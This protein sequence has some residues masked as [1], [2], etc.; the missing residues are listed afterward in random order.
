MVTVGVATGFGHVVQLNPVAG[1][2]TKLLPPFTFNI[3]ELPI[4]TEGFTAVAV[5]GPG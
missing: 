1:L 4:Q 2:Q 5:G 3:V